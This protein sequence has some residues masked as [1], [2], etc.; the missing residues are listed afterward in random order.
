MTTSE[1]WEAIYDALDTLEVKYNTKYCDSETEALIE[2]WTHTAGQDIPTEFDYDGSPED[3]VKQ[4]A[5]RAENYDVDNEVELYVDMRGQRGV[6]KTVREL[7]DDCQEA[8]DT[9]MKIAEE[10]KKAIS[11]EE[12]NL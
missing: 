7:L 3:F 4:F 2:F 8:K 10:L 9:L 5:E 12:E 6:P 1:K 11:E